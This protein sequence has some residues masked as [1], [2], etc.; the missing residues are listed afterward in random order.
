MNSTQSQATNTP[1]PTLHGVKIKQRKGVQKAQAKHE[2]EIFRDNLLSQLALAKPGDLEDISSILDKT[3]NTLEYRKYGESLFEILITGGIL[4]P[5]GIILD[6]VERS[7]FS[8]FGAEDESTSIKKHVDVFNKLIRRYKYLQRP[9]EE[10]LKNILQFINKWQVDENSKLAKA[11]GYFITTQLANPIVFKVLLKDYLVKDGHSLVFAT[12]VFR[13]I[14]TEQNID[15]LGK[16]LVLSGMD[17]RLLELFPPNK[18]EEECLS[19]HFEAEDMKQL[20]GFH[21]RNQKNSMKG[22]LLSNLKHL[23]SEETPV[24]E[25]LTV[26]KEAKKDAGLDE[27]DVIPIIWTAIIDS[28]DLMNTR[29]DQVESSVLR[30]LNQW[31]RLLEN[32]TASPKTEILLL[33]RV[34]IT[35]YEDAKVTKVFRQIIQLLY[36]NDVLSDNAILYWA[37]KAHKPQGKTVFLKQMAPFVQWLRDNED[38]SEEED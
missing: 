32:Y 27:S 9:F 36:K 3:G 16:Y 21:Q 23:L 15:Q 12:A 1:K 38:S 34:Q 5:G 14:L 29:P 19:R 25:V 11:T 6:D 17:T 7:P 4:Q 30:G 18:R 20:V 24:E 10:T 22:D 8:I 35:C 2:P 13:T 37:D 28:V 33:Q 31:S 26:I